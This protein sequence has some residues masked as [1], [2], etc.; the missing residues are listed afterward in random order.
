MQRLAI[1]GAGG[2]AREVRWLIEELNRVR[3]QF[4]FVGYVVADRGVPGRYDSTDSIAGDEAWLEAHAGDV[5]ALAIGIGNPRVRHA[6][7]RRLAQR[8]P[9]LSFPP[10][11]HP[12][13]MFD[14]GSCRFAEGVIVSAGVIATVNVRVGAFAKVDTACTL[15]HEVEIGAGTVINPGARI[16]GGVTIGENTLIGTGAQILQYLKVGDGATVGAGA[17]VTTDVAPNT[18]VV[19]VP[20]RPRPDR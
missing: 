10:V 3:S 19:G 8:L 9:G 12:S 16:S 13:V 17:V 1:V 15:A 7:G 2:F 4:M 18:T 14:A 6:V 5:D 20:A 11:I